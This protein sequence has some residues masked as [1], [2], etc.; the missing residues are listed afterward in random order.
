MKHNLII[1]I[2]TLLF[3]IGLVIPETFAQGT[4]KIAG[5]LSDKSGEALIGV[6]VKLSEMNKGTM[7]DVEGRYNLSG[8]LAGTYTLQF[9]YV[10]FSTKK[11]SD[12]IVSAGKVTTLD[13]VMEEGGQQQ[14]QAVVITATAKQESIGGLYIQ[15]KNSVTISSGISADIIKRSPDRS[16]SD[17]LKRVSGASIQDNKFVVV[18]GLSDRYNSA[19]INGA[20]LPSSEPDKKAF[21]FDIFPSNLIDR[22][23]INKTASPDLPGDFAGGVVQIITKDVPDQDFLELSLGSGYNTQSTGKPFVSNGRGSTDW[24]GVVSSDRKVPSNFPES[25]ENYAGLSNSQKASAS[26][27]LPNA[28]GEVQ[29][30]ALPAQNYQLTW[31]KRKDLKNDGTI[32]SIFSL[33]Y[34]NAQSLYNYERTDWDNPNTRTV[35]IKKFQDEQSRLNVSWGGIGNISYKMGNNKFSWKNSYSRVLD[36][37]YYNRTGINLN[38]N[39][40]LNFRSNDPSQRSL[41]NTQFEG[42]HLLNSKQWKL[43]WNINYANINREQTDLRTL[44]YA[45]S[46]EGADTRFR[47]V[48]RNSRRFFSDLNENNYGGSLNFT[49]PFKLKD[50]K[51]T[52]K[53]GLLGLYKNRNFSSRIF[54]YQ[55]LPSAD[56][57][58]TYLPYNEIFNSENISTNGFVLNEFTNPEDTYVAQSMLGAGYFMF[59]SPIA[60]KIRAVYGLRAEYYNQNLDAL[61]LNLTRVNADQSYLDILPSLN[62]S[63]ALTEKSNF[64][65]SGSRTVSRPEFRE[66][67][68]FAFYDYQVGATVRGNESLQRSSNWNTDMRYE[69]YPASGESFTVSTFY[70]Y[71][72]NP[73]E[74]FVN[75]QTNSDLRVF[76]YSNSKSATT[77]GVE[78]DFRKKLNF[79]RSELLNNTTAFANAAYISSEVITPAGYGG[80]R[81]LQA[82]SPYLLNAGL[83]YF[84]PNAGFTFT[85]LFNQIGQ[86]LNVAGYDSENSAGFDYPHWYENARSVIDLQFSERVFRKKGELKLNISDILNQESVV[87]QNLDNKKAYNKNIDRNIY[88]FKPGTSISLSL[89]YKF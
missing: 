67:A 79:L 73:I 51:Q 87:Y 16:T 66:L 40:N 32:G 72:Q 42:D 47:M 23:V 62:I 29:T 37:L 13:V 74:L 10:G 7:T 49:L 89:N 52:F 25:S 5:K 15:Q 60:K 68:P 63:Y 20:I 61:K 28:Y 6:S 26:K 27:L 8:L 39:V 71:F 85:A 57:S 81:P 3:F 4:G 65:L 82:Q 75:P 48:D 86:R 36:E 35:F 12:I 46:I 1:R 55:T 11:I 43:N 70:K 88:K 30:T 77:F 58:L 38:N 44:E 45:Q 33:T 18:R 78:I 22:I 84:A 19:Q 56:E 31:G 2:L 21:S 64:R 83:Q 69:F 14:L 80:N 54:H 41:Y 9:S 50:T 76:E 59:D 17:V 53:A 34:R 24:L